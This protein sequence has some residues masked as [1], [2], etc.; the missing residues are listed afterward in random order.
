MAIAAVSLAHDQQSAI[1]VAETYIEDRLKDPFSARFRHVKT[2]SI[3]DEGRR[4]VNVCGYVYAKDGNGAYNGGSQFVVGVR[5][6]SPGGLVWNI[7]NNRE[8]AAILGSLGDQACDVPISNLK[9]RE[10]EMVAE[11]LE[12]D[13]AAHAQYGL[14]QKAREGERALAKGDY[15]MQAI[16]AAGKHELECIAA[17]QVEWRRSYSRILGFDWTGPLGGH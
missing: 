5:N 17:A 7:D 16:L 14:C 15:A 11:E 10:R 2:R 8:A 12:A 3:A 9:A 13:D 1:R 6:G 4:S